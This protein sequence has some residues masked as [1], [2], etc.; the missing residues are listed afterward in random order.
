MIRNIAIVLME[1]IHIMTF[2]DVQARSLF[3]SILFVTE[4]NLRVLDHAT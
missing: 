1:E 3:D 4:Y 2:M